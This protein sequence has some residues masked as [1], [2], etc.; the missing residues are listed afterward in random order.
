M[1]LV[2]APFFR[3]P[4]ALEYVGLLEIDGLVIPSTWEVIP[5]SSAAAVAK[6]SDNESV[7]VPLVPRALCAWWSAEQLAPS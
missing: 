7:P 5:I 3:L 1:I 4:G 6:K 2:V